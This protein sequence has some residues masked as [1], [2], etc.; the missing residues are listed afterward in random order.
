M[1]SALK[2]CLIIFRG[3]DATI[4]FLTQNLVD[5][6][7]LYF[8]AIPTEKESYANDLLLRNGDDK[9]MSLPINLFNFY[10]QA[11]KKKKKN[12]SI[13]RYCLEI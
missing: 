5:H 3:M 9:M 11:L 10:G 6:Q 2:R 12:A 8:F 4:S 1:A 13:Q 7:K